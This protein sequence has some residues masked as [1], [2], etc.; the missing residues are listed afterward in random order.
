MASF[1][2]ILNILNLRLLK[3]YFKKKIK[4]K[5]PE[6]IWWYQNKCLPL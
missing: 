3:I 5:Y 6:K 2:V 1:Y 4:K